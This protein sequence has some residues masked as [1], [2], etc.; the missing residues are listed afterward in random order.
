[1]L[2]SL[3][4]AAV[5]AAAWLRLERPR[6]DSV[7]VLVVVALA[8][9]PALVRPRAVAV[10]VALVL[11]CRV[12]L[13]TWSPHRCATR[14]A[15]GFLDFY[16]VQVPFD[17]RT[18]AAMQGVVLAAILGFVLALG[19]VVASRRPIAALLV[20]LAGAGWPATL[21][22]SGVGLGV[23]ILGA[24]LVVLAGMSERRLPRAAIPAAAAIAAAALVA[25]GSSAVAPSGGLVGWR[26][27]DFYDA[28][29]EP[30]S[31][32]Y[33][34][35]AQYGGISFPAKRTVVLEVKAPARSL[36][37]R[38]A[39][40]DVF[41]ADRWSEGGL[42]DVAAPR[43]RLVR[44]DVAVKALAETRLV[45]ASVPLRFDAGDAPLTRTPSGAG[46]GSGLS[47]GLRYTVWSYAPQPTPAELAASPPRYPAKLRKTFLDVWPG[48]PMP[49]FGAGEPAVRERLDAHPEIAR[50]TQLEH[51]AFAVAGT[52]RTPYA[53]AAAL[54]SWFRVRGGFTYT[55]RPAVFAAAPLVG[56]VAQTRAGYCQYF[57]G[58]M[59]LMLRYLGV[60]A[61][62]AVGFSSGAYDRGRGVW[63]VTD[64]DAHAWVETWFR[65]YGWLPFDP[66]P[67]AGSPARGRLSAAYATRP[68]RAGAA[69]SAPA[70]SASRHRE[71]GT[72]TVPSVGAVPAKSHQ[73]LLLLLALLV[74]G[75]PA[76]LAATKL[77]VRRVR[78][79][80]RDPR[81]V[82][83]ACRRELADF[84]RDQRI[85]V[86]GSA[87]LHE[88]GAIVRDELTVDPDAFVA[89]ATAARFGPPAGS[90]AAAQTAR[91][92]LR[93][94][95][96][97]VRRRL[98]VRERVRGSLS[99]RSL[100]LAP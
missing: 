17:P 88:L 94:L 80:S 42:P 59:A 77:A 99:L 12:A 91:R 10:A 65:G 8:L 11:G 2:V 50:Y 72:P 66:T 15:H 98:G 37:W 35:D 74:G 92:E 57:A 69:P 9:V 46:I 22:G 24:A 45:G 81:R 13:G 68:P 41:A 56:F 58:A 67:S 3:L 85:G 70:Q 95:V 78:Y 82:A 23:A 30:V 49:P 4:P 33:V 5:V 47:R 61:R 75:V 21:S 19:L 55:N 18:H 64:H 83:G 54:E 28:L 26:Q 34:W 62:V 20:L 90:R 40:L 97:L 6:D 60:P 71:H 84:L 38:A 76:G 39:V 25:S 31:V 48:V 1:V 87:T 43:G 63:T 93:A 52:A 29:D 53:A 7:A 44:Q 100:G 16:D 14:F 36:Y 96:R 79:V 27:W 32:D 86:A 73:I 51:A 89:A